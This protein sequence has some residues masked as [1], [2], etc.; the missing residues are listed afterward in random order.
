MAVSGVDS[1]FNN[2]VR[3]LVDGIAGSINEVEQAASRPRGIDERVSR[4][5]HRSGTDGCCSYLRKPAP[6]YGCL[7]ALERDSES[8]LAAEVFDE[9]DGVLSCPSEAHLVLGVNCQGNSFLAVL[10]SFPIFRGQGPLLT[11]GEAPAIFESDLPVNDPL[12]KDIAVALAVVGSYAGAEPIG[13]II[14]SYFRPTHF[15]FGKQTK[16]ALT[17][18][19]VVFGDRCQGVSGIRNPGERG[20]D[21][22]TDCSCAEHRFCRHETA[23]G[24]SDALILESIRAFFCGLLGLNCGRRGFE[25][26][27]AYLEVADR[28]LRGWCCALDVCRRIN[29]SDRLATRPGGASLAGRGSVPR[30]VD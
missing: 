1:R 10:N 27:F 5:G 25:N 16:A 11:A 21:V 30:F 18:R 2:D 13:L 8:Q 17:S 19:E 29:R 20:V 4:S 14:P 23:G 7:W 24:D 6:A 12:A 22:A 28:G 15:G 9:A 3:R 26:L